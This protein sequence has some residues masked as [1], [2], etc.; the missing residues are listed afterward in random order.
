MEM[1]QN[2]YD[3]RC[4]DSDTHSNA[5]LARNHGFSRAPG[6]GEITGFSPS[7]NRTQFVGHLRVNATTLARARSD[8]FTEFARMQIATAKA[9]FGIP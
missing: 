2:K 4:W 3:G 1:F 7:Q 5:V 9:Q 8:V 6:H